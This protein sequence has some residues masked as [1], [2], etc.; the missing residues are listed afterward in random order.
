MADITSDNLALAFLDQKVAG[1]FAGKHYAYIVVPTDSQWELGIAVANERG[2]SP[3][4]GSCW[5]KRTDA[6]AVAD[7]MN[8]HIGLSE[9]ES[10]EILASSMRRSR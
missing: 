1:Q 9:A 10:I 8:A 3:V 7:G 2:Y 4:T 5:S 6:Q